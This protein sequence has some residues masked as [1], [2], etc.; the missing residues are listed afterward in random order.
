MF[1]FFLSNKKQKVSKEDCHHLLFNNR[2]FARFL[3]KKAHCLNGTFLATVFFSKP[4]I[5][6][7]FIQ[8]V[9]KI[10]P[11]FLILLQSSSTYYI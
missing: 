11:I 4:E 3:F 7:K 5:P 6:K 1:L 2:D 10:V 9:K 8:E